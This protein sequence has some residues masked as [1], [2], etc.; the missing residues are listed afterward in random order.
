MSRTDKF[1]VDCGHAI[2]ANNGKCGLIEDVLCRA[3]TIVIEFEQ[4]E[5]LLR[6][7][8][9]RITVEAIALGAASHPAG[10]ACSTCEILHIANE[11]AKV[12]EA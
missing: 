3:T 5:K 7:A 4:R 8:I 12:G 9:D 10:H 1:L 2:N 11:A 6:S